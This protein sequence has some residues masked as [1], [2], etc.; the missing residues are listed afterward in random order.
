MVITEDMDAPGPDRVDAAKLWA[1][2]IATAVVAGFAVVAGVLVTRGVFGI[3]V[4]APKT[5]GTFGNF[6]TLVYA[7]R[8]A[9]CALLAT[10]LLHALLL[11]TPRPI[12]FFTWI[13]ALAGVAAAAAPFTESAPAAT[14]IFTALI[15][16]V[17]GAAVISLLPGV[18][19]T[20]I[21]PTAI[22]PADLADQEPPAGA[23]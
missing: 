3:P 14:K 16:I 17:V 18:G 22:R 20:A 11:G 6:A 9:A 7:G 8:A 2:G 13:S 1:G 12:A 4:A 10:A 21:R 19:R 23:C 5:A 15:N